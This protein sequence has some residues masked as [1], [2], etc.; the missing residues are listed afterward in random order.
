MVKQVSVKLASVKSGLARVVGAALLL[1]ATL[2][3]GPADAVPAKALVP[4][5]AATRSL[6]AAKDMDPRAPILIRAFKKES[7]L[8]VWKMNRA[9]RYVHLKTYPICRWSGQLGPKRKTGDR[10]TPEGFY[11]IPAA[12]M[13]PNSSYHLSFDLGYPNAYDRAHGSTGS[14][15]MTHGTCSSMGCFAMTDAQISEI[16][17]LA[18]DSLNAGQRAF[19]FQAYPFRMTAQNMARARTEAH[20]DFW[21]QLKE[22]YDRFEATGEEPAVGVS[23]RRYTFAP[24]RNPAR[25]AAA[26]A[27]IAEE[28][29]KTETL[30][31]EG[32]AAVRVTYA[33]GGMHA[34]FA[35]LAK[36]GAGSLGTV[37][38]PETLAMAGREVIVIPARTTPAV[39]LAIAPIKPDFL[40]IEPTTTG[41]TATA[42]L[43]G[44]A[45]GDVRALFARASLGGA[46][47]MSVPLLTGSAAILPPAFHPHP[48]AK[49]A[50]RGA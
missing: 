15:L 30:I 37:S 3:S 48:V 43:V 46:A 7:E 32:A 27:R 34:S 38:R 14:Y 33:D 39:L 20:L 2:S 25:E 18:R 44:T 28:K 8:E 45:S 4:V 11:S 26:V 1:A 36:R 17:A 40:K 31:A 9:G 23:G 24:Y 41:S 42:A 6:M 35:A 47:S 16:Y 21:R 13:N 12:K 10:Q 22:G 29:T 19:Q 49:V 50:L 5:P